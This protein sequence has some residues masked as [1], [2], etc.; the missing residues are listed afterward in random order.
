MSDMS[1]SEKQNFIATVVN[2]NF[3]MHLHR[4]NLLE[5]IYDCET[6]NEFESKVD[7]Y[8]RSKFWDEGEEEIQRKLLDQYRPK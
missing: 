8:I 1:E 6:E 2:N 7:S 3:L 4:L 5:E